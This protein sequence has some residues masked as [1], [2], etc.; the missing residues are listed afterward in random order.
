MTY[1]FKIVLVP[2][3][4]L[5]AACGGKKSGDGGNQQQGGADYNKVSGTIENDNGSLTGDGQLVFI[6]SLGS[7]DAQKSFGLT[8]SL[9]NGASLTIHT[10]SSNKLEGG[11]DFE[12][13]R[14]A[15]NV[16]LKIDG[17]EIKNDIGVGSD[18]ALSVALEVHNNESPAHLIVEVGGSEIY[19]GTQ[20]GWTQGGGVYWGLTLKN[21][22]VSDKSVGPPKHGH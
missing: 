4:L 15:N 20:G 19:D 18:G 13:K 9:E 14:N 12:F 6:D 22:V 3:V 11:L 8:F 5:V 17:V 10:F 1:L 2:V 7:T 16:V 21:A